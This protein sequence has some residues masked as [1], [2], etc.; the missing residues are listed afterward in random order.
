MNE[1]LDDNVLQVILHRFNGKPESYFVRLVC[2]RWAKI[3]QPTQ[4]DIIAVAR[5]YAE[6]GNKAAL[7]IL[8]GIYP[9]Y[10][11]SKYLNLKK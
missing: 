5:C 1:E 7:E 8:Q 3:V 11:N 9:M 6:Y 2:N 10:S 4:N